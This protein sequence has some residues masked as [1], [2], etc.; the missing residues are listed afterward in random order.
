MGIL[1]PVA[2][3]LETGCAEGTTPG[4]TC[5]IVHRGAVV[6]R[7]AHGITAVRPAEAARPVRPETIYDVASLTKVMATTAVAMA[8]HG[9]RRLD[10]D[11]PVVRLLP[12]FVRASG[13]RTAVL[14]PA[15]AASLPGAEAK[16]SVTV[17]DLLAHRS[18]LPAWRPF[19]ERVAGDWV[20]SRVFKAPADRPD[21][22]GRAAAFRRARHLCRELVIAEPLEAAPRSRAVYSDPGFIVLGMALEAAAGAG[23]DALFD[24]YVAGPLGLSSTRFVDGTDVGSRPVT[25][26]AATRAAGSRGGAV[27][28]G[29]VDDDNAHALA[30]VAGHAGLF[31]TA[32]DVAAFGEAVRRAHGGERVGALRPES[33][34]AFLVR[35]RDTPES[36]RAFGFDTPSPGESAAGRL[37]DR[38][39]SFGHLGFTGCSLWID[40]SRDLTVALLTNRVHVDEDPARIRALRADVHDAAV[41]ATGG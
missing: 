37:M 24:R 19:W 26:A 36:T 11:L 39:A 32:D 13:R 41:A 14:P 40:L 25:G 22:V 3:R 5:V 6:H 21:A 28:V 16:A 30:G 10:L 12:A 8:L 9:E 23:L 33:V 2:A 29:E 35:D 4:A 34:R 18:G 20:A 7:S 27:L 38:E 1:D 15:L 17:A 31:S